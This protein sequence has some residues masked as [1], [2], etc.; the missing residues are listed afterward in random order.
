MV[1]QQINETLG[2]MNYLAGR[3]SYSTITV[4][5]NPKIREVTPTPTATPT[6]TPTPYP[7]PTATPWNPGKTFNSAGTKLGDSY[8]SIIDALIWL[9]V[10]V[11]PIFAPWIL[12]ALALFL[13]FR[14]KKKQPSDNK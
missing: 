13:I 6:V 8:R 10:Y 9:T 4:T 14:R 1:E 3:A 11:L 7:S 2:R 12:I 5:I